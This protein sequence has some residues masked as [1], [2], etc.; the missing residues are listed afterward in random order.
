M[1]SKGVLARM[2]TKNLNS[3]YKTGNNIINK[4]YKEHK[5]DEALIVKKGKRAGLNLILEHPFR[6]LLTMIPFAWRG[7]FVETGFVLRVPFYAVLYSTLAVNVIYFVSLFIGLFLAFRKK[8]WELWPF[9][10]P[11]LYLYGMNTL[12]THCYGRFNKPAIP[13]MIVTSLFLVY[14]FNNRKRDKNAELKMQKSPERQKKV[15]PRKRK[16]TSK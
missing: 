7:I 16:L 15:L 10:L 11:S 12:L 3:Y 5:G 6:H 8:M 4:I 13:L 14:Y 9:V 2:N 1:G